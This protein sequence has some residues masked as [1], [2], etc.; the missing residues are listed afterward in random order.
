MKVGVF[1]EEFSPNV[2]GGYTIQA[3]VF[4]SL[5]ELA[6]ESE[7]RFTIFCRQPE[8]LRELLKSTALETMAFPGGI[9]QR[10]VSLASRGFATLRSKRKL[11]TRLEEMAQENGIEF[12]WFVGAE[13][14]QVDLPYCAIVWD[15]QH[16]L[17]PWFPEV[18]ANREWEH[19]EAFYS[20]F[21]RR[22]AV[23]FVGTEAGRQEVERFY[24]VPPERIQILPHPT[25][26]FALQTPPP[27]DGEQVLVRYGLS[28]GYLFYPAQFWAHK[29]HINLLL[30]VAR[31]RKEHGLSL[32]VVFVGSDKGNEPYIRET[33]TRLGLA[34]QV[35]FLGFVSQEELVVLYRNA[36]ALAYLSFF[37]PENLPPLEAF[38][39][40]C[41][42]IA[43]NVAGS[44]EQL[45]D[46]AL[47]VNPTD[48][49]GIASAIKTLHDDSDLSSTLVT[50][51]LKR[52]KSWTGH[53]FVKRVFCMLDEFE[54]IRRCWPAQA[55]ARNIA[56]EM[57]PPFERSDD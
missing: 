31:V 20:Q 41:P 32:D 39:L 10:L 43:A 45:G 24:D 55:P 18:S 53:D 22:A 4:Q 48:V 26:A 30:A 40:G 46:A 12:I 5:I 7:H 29:N 23:I 36:F 3:D 44:H 56:S 33:C 34:E 2:G 8:A 37:G 11:Q 9:P 25:P 14:V 47:L 28:P 13:A 27:E 16:R 6:G 50:R 35:H 49:N 42:V 15:L 21:L 17:Q 52:A 19:R 51:G 1:L 57:G 38:A 54:K